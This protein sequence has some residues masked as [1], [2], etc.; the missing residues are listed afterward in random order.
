MYNNGYKAKP[1]VLL[2]P[3]IKASI[4]DQLVYGT[5]KRLYEQ[6]VCMIYPSAYLVS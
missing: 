1:Y 5:V 6:I 4:N 2:E 3:I